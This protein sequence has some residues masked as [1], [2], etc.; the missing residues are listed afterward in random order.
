MTNKYS[1][2]YNVKADPQKVGM[3]LEAIYEENGKLTPPLI[4]EDARNADRETHRLIEWN[5]SAA[6]EN[7]RLEQAR[8]IVRNII[9]VR[10]E[11]APEK[12][13]PKVIQIHSESNPQAPEAKVIK[14]RA[15]ENVDVEEGRYFMPIQDAVNRDDTRNYMLD[16]A[17]KALKSFRSKYGMIKELAI[18]LDAIDKVEREFTSIELAA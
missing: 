6:A 15:F 13:E 11:P 18:V 5:D 10:S 4:V 12:T 16:Q 1:W 3:E 14:F 8:Y 9:I 7:Y 17:L 2:K